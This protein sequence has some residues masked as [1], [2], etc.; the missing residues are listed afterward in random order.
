MDFK[1]SDPR[2]IGVELEYQLLDAETL[3][4]ADRIVPLMELF[5]AGNHIKPEFIQN[6]V[7]VTSSVHHKLDSLERELIQQTAHLS[8]KCRSLGIRLA[9]AGTHPF[10]E[11]LSMLTP[12]PRYQQLEEVAGLLAHTQITFSTHVHLGM[13]TGEEM[14]ALMRSLKPYLPLLI[15]ISANSPFWFGYDTGFA[16]YRQRILAGSRNYGIPP[17]FR[18]WEEFVG[19]FSTLQQA[20]M[21]SSMRDLH[22]DIRPRPDFGTLEVRVMDAQATVHHAVMLAGFVRALIFFLRLQLEDTSQ[23]KLLEPVHWFLEKQNYFE[24][25]RLG[26]KAHLVKDESGATMPLSEL[27][28]ELVE[29]LSPIAEDLGQAEYLSGLRHF[30]QAGPGYILQWEAFEDRGSL[31]D[32]AQKLSEALGQELMQESLNTANE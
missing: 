6:T 30:V 1:P 2:S 25:T 20:G 21:A 9:G 19:L 29:K 18:S 14:L 26:M 27:F 28:N 4:L 7:E 31:R 16:D 13:T 5:P 12:M 11:R 3:D 10:S 15:G 32:V 17:S 8:E 23:P 22:W 24:A